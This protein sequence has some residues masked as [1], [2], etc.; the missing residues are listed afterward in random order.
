LN[1]YSLYTLCA[2]NPPRDAK[3]LLAIYADVNQRERNDLTLGEDFSAAAALSRAWCQLLP[4]GRAV[5]V[6]HDPEALSLARAHPRVRLVQSD[7][8]DAATKVDLL[9]VL[10]FSIGELHRRSRLLAYF[11]HARSRLKPRGC[12]VCDIYGGADCFNTGTVSQRILGPRGQRITYRWEQRTADPLTAR[13]TNAMHFQISRTGAKSIRL[14]DAFV[15][16]WRLW[17]V[18]ELREAMLDAGFA[19]VQVYPRTADATDQDGRLYFSPIEDAH[20]LAAG[21]NVFVVART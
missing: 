14:H 12:L 16:N 4:K 1:K 18:P 3:A 10:N 8:F 21:F 6:D 5:A 15:Y 17:S 19:D 2:Q 7:V 13:V 20:E 9:A 11:K